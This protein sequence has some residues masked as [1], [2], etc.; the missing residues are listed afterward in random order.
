MQGATIELDLQQVMRKGLSLTSSTL[1]PKSLAE[2]MRLAQCISK[3]LLPLIAAGKIAPRIYQ[4]LPLAQA[5]EAI[6]FWKPTPISVKCCW[7]W[8]HD[9][10]LF[11]QHVR[12][13]S[14]SDG[15]RKRTGS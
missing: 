15:V 14:Q 8:R 7:R 3:H 4:T 10:T 5:A 11:C 2:K 6:A 9:A 13:C 1:R 12:L